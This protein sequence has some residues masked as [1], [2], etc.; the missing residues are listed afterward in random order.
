MHLMPFVVVGMVTASSRR[1]KEGVQSR[2]DSV[3]CESV[4]QMWSSGARSEQRHEKKIPQQRVSQQCRAGKKIDC[5]QLFWLSRSGGGCKRA[6]SK[7]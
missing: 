7:L 2:S 5:W 4:W 6:V 3:S 1:K